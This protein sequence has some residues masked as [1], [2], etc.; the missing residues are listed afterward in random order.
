MDEKTRS[1]LIIVD[2]QMDFMPSGVLPIAGADEIVEPINQ[3]IRTG[4]YDVII[5]TQDWHPPDHISFK[6]WPVHC[7]AGTPGA[8]LHPRLDQRKISVIFRKGMDKKREEYSAF[9]GK[10][11]HGDELHEYLT[12]FDIFS[13]DVVGLAFDYCVRFTAADANGYFLTHIIKDCTRTAIPENEAK[14]L[15]ALVRAGVEVV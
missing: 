8:E 9:A 12:A 1:A 7:V 11:K 2:L 4:K 15:R 6:K 14:V 3:L 13:C 10:S 5:A